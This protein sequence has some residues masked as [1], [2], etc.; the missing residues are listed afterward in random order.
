VGET[1]FLTVS[2]FSKSEVTQEYAKLMMGQGD[3]FASKGLYEYEIA[4]ISQKNYSNLLKN[5][6][7]ISYF[8]FFKTGNK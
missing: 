8:E 1:M 2:G 7:I 4:W 6:R 5:N 3:M